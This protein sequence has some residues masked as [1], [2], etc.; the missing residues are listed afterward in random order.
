M[1]FLGMTVVVT[2]ALLG[3][4]WL[5]RL[6]KRGRGV[7]TIVCLAWAL[8]DA[9]W[10][11]RENRGHAI[12]AFT[13]S[14]LDS[15]SP[16]VLWRWIS[17]GIRRTRE[18]L[19]T[20]SPLAQKARPSQTANAHAMPQTPLSLQHEA[21]SGCSTKEALNAVNQDTSEPE[22]RRWPRL[23]EEAKE[24]V[25]RE[26]KRIEDQGLLRTSAAKPV[27]GPENLARVETKTTKPERSLEHDHTQQ[28]THRHTWSGGV[29]TISADAAKLLIPEYVKDPAG[30][31]HD[32]TAA[33]RAISSAA[34]DTVLACAP[35]PSRD[36]ALICAG[37]PG[38]G[39][40]ATLKS[41][42]DPAVGLKIEETLDELDEARVILQRLID[43][44]R[45]P[46]ILWMYVDDPKKTVERMFRRAMKI[47]RTDQLDGMA[48]A[49]TKVPDVLSVLSSEFAGRLK[50]HVADN[51]GA[52]GELQFVEDSS[53]IWS[54]QE[55]AI[56]TRV[57]LAQ[58]DATNRMFRENPDFEVE[59]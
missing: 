54:E 59:Y 15:V 21:L 45:K 11:A 24:R 51:S 19:W 56:A 49:Y 38:S 27:I 48:R 57:G 36:I 1:V 43:S 30:A 12:F 25:L 35:E 16:L 50:V 13:I 23:S 47:G 33:A 3:A 39:K 52:R 42:S 40:T 53:R 10:S 22:E 4:E 8:I 18:R 7:L 32:V 46:V 29:V 41:L 6:G 20:R 31:D 28:R 5:F 14:F 55:D 34:L 37:S 44:G 17:S 58:V 26:F 2:I 9:V